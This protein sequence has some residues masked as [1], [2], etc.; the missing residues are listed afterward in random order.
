MDSI[1]VILIIV[2]RTLLLPNANYEKIIIAWI[3]LGLSLIC[4]IYVAMVLVGE[5][6]DK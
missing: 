1:M 4:K 5:D 3:C 6:I 2:F